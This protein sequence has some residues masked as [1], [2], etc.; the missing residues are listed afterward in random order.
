MGIGNKPEK[1][2]F[3]DVAVW[4]KV[5]RDPNSTVWLQKTPPD[6]KYNAVTYT[7][8]KTRVYP[9]ADVWRKP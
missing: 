3:K 9:M 6:G 8:E 5:Y 7:G 4:E 2:K 1:V